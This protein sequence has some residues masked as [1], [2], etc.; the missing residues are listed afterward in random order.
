M[1]FNDIMTNLLLPMVWSCNASPPWRFHRS[2]HK[3]KR[4][5]RNDSEWA[6]QKQIADP[7]SGYS[8]PGTLGYLYLVP[9]TLDNLASSSSTTCLG[10]Q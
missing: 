10:A 9:F 1:Y 3:E 6:E 4:E 2:P 8:L 5:C 7:M